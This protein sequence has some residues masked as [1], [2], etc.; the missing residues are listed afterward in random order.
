MT[1]IPNGFAEDS[2]GLKLQKAGLTRLF[3]GKVRDTYN[4]GI[5]GLMLVV[6]SNRIS[7]NDVVLPAFIPGKGKVL[8]SIS[9]FFMTEVLSDFPNHLVATG[10][11]ILQYLPQELWNDPE[12]TERGTIIRVLKML[13]AEFIVRGYL[14]GSGWTAYQETGEVCGHVLTTGLHDGSQLNPP[15]FTPT[16]KAEEGHD[17]HMSFKTIRELYGPNPEEFVLALYKRSAA[18]A[19]GRGIILADTKYELGYNGDILTLGDESN[20]PDSSRYWMRVAWEAAVQNR[21]SPAG[22]DKQPVRDWGKTIVTPFYKGDQ[23]IIG[24]GNL[25][26]KNSDHIAF[27]HNMEIPQQVLDHC[28]ERY[29]RIN[30]M[31]TGC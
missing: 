5:E 11:Q 1:K 27:V 28:A 21:K 10:N 14:T 4:I 26:L 22:F 13:P 30:E 16:S 6:A 29:D 20:T 15:I 9:N 7:I 17:E 3:Q 25:D 24:I 12:L 8:T 2:L 23:Q 19:G 31:L 18:Y